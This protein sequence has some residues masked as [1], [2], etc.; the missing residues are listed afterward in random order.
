MAILLAAEIARRISGTEFPAF[1]EQAVFRPL[2]MD[3]SAL[4]LGRFPLEA[5]M[6]CQAEDAVPESGAGDPAARDRGRPAAPAQP[7]LG[8]R[9]RVRGLKVHPACPKPAAGNR[10]FGVAPKARPGL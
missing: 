10:R 1:L 8:S 7:R 9:G 4:G 2:K 5:M 3:H 6:R